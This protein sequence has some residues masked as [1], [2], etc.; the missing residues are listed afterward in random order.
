MKK[1]FYLV[2]LAALALVGC[3]D[4]DF[5]GTGNSP[6][7]PQEGNGA[8]S[9]FIGSDK[10]T[11]ADITGQEAAEKLNQQ[12]IVWGEK[13]ED[14]GAAASEGNLVFE[15]YV[16]KYEKNS[17]GTTESN[18]SNWEYVGIKPYDADKVSPALDIQTEDGNQSI[19][20]W[21][22]S[23]KNY[24]YSAF[25]ALP[26]DI[27]SGKI[28]V[29]KNETGSDECGNEYGKG[30]DMTIN[31]DASLKDIYFA[32]RAP[33]STKSYES[34]IT[35]ENNQVGNVVKL[36]FRAA[37]SKIRFAVYETVPGY[38]IQITKMYFTDNESEA[39]TSTTTNF[40]IDG[41]F[42]EIGGTPATMHVDYYG[43]DAKDAQNNSITNQPKV[44]VTGGDALSS[45]KF[46]DKNVGDEVIGTQSNQATYDLE[47]KE[48]TIILPN[49]ENDKPMKLKVDYKLTS[50]DGSKEVINVKHATAVVPATFCQWQPN[51]AYTYLFKISDNTNGNTGTPGQDP[52]GLYPI[53]FDAVVADA[54]IGEQQTITTVANPSITTYANGV[55]VTENN[56]Y[57]VN[58]DIY[59]AVM[60]GTSPIE[61]T[62]TTQAKVYRAFALGK[63]EITERALQNAGAYGIILEPISS[64]I[65]EK[66]AFVT[67]IPMADG[68]T[69]EIKALK[70]TAKAPITYVF[71]YNNGATKEYKVIKVE[72]SGSFQ[73]S[74]A[75]G[76][77]LAINN[78]ATLTNQTITLKDNGLEVIGAEKYIKVT[79][80]ATNAAATDLQITESTSTPGTYE[81]KFTDSGLQAGHSGIYTLTI[82]EGNPGS[83][84]TTV[85]VANK[86]DITGTGISAVTT[87]TSYKVTIDGSKSTVAT[88]KYDTKAINGA[89]TTNNDDVTVTEITGSGND[90][91]YTIAVVPSAAT[92]TKDVTIAGKTITV[93]IKGYAITAGADVYMKYNDANIV[94]TFTTENEISDDGN[95][96]VNGPTGATITGISEASK[97]GQFTTTKGGKYEI[98]YNGYKAT[99][100]VHQYSAEIN[101]GTITAKNGTATMTITHNG[102]IEGNHST[103]TITIVKGAS[104]E[105]T[106]EVGGFTV[107][108]SGKQIQIKRNGAQAGTYTVKYVVNDVIVAKAVLKVTSTPGANSTETVNTGTIAW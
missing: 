39:E 20:Y 79:P 18:S 24:V 65:D 46:G 3:S 97:N 100:T 56:E 92:A 59:V 75:W 72:G 98:E 37:A 66:Q 94:S 71:E 30:Y 31:N 58:D 36:T 22:Y 25:S 87:G 48:Y 80:P 27:E 74:Y 95:I 33:I 11:R 15:N 90:G 76:P 19:K 54:V 85:D 104:A 83:S 10:T 47:N 14:G 28:S 91:K 102:V 64:L 93:T 41:G 53:T 51:F 5:F 62:S 16:V 17:A 69:K 42:T 8:V 26:A 52:A 78:E 2:G 32:D 44:S 84:S 38:Q 34:P 45:M 81:V 6:E 63:Q 89:L 103:A 70:F 4:N 86:Y 77:K 7:S 68:S 40:A 50:T 73:N 21:D 82:A 12:F 57:R 9:F 49:T 105:G 101:P 1:P 96:H 43:A 67:E 61:L 108:S 107:D 29:K 60:N 23:A 55:I 88:L 106:T 35:G 99:N 13:N